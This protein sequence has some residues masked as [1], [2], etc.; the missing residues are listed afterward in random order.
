MKFAKIFRNVAVLALVLSVSLIAYAGQTSKTDDVVQSICKQMFTYPSD[1]NK[2]LLDAASWKG[3]PVFG[4]D[5]PDEF[6]ERPPTRYEELLKE[7]YGEF[8]TEEAYGTFV[9][10]LVPMEAV[11]LAIENQKTMEFVG[12]ENMG[13]ESKENHR[14]E[15]MVTVKVDDSQVQQKLHVTEEDGKLV[16][17]NY[18]DDTLKKALGGN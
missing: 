4:M 9:K 11:K 3:A 5:G 6:S 15:Y 14:A 10:T 17:F 13:Q 16:Y 2:E 8:F 1:N 18:A 12:L 7:M